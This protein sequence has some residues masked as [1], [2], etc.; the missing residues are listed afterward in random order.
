MTTL[1]TVPSTWDSDRDERF[2]R[3]T[4]HVLPCC[5]VEGASALLASY[6]EEPVVASSE[7]R[8]V[9]P[10]RRPLAPAAI[11]GT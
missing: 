9:E 5:L 3:I 4:A 2:F 8:R 6:D 1:E 11:S 10:A 7:A